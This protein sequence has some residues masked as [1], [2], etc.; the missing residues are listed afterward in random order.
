MLKNSLGA[1]FGVA[2]MRRLDAFTAIFGKRIR[3]L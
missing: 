2:G 1:L 3:F